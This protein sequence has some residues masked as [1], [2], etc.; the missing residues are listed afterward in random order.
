MTEEEAIEIGNIVIGT[1]DSVKFRVE[2]KESAA[3]K[4]QYWKVH[5]EHRGY[6]K[7]LTIDDQG[8]I[9]VYNKHDDGSHEIY[10]KQH[11]VTHYLLSNHFDLFNL[12]PR[13]LE[14]HIRSNM[15]QQFDLA[16]VRL[17]LERCQSSVSALENFKSK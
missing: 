14:T 4:F 2:K 5:K 3:G 13:G 7:S 11:Y 1:Y 8:E 10:M 16:K 12:I 6:G 15:D 9:D 17:F